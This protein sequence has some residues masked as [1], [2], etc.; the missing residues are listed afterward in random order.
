MTIGHVPAILFSPSSDIIIKV[1][2]EYL[3]EGISKG[4]P[5]L[6]M[7]LDTMNDEYWNYCN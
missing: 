4:A 3:F 2:L 1:S 5:C 6:I 7:V